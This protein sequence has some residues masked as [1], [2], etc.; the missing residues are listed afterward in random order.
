MSCCQQILDPLWVV[1]SANPWVPEC[2]N[3]S[4]G[5]WWREREWSNY[6]AEDSYFG[7]GYGGQFV[8]IFPSWDMIIVANAKWGVAQSEANQ[9]ANQILNAIDDNILSAVGD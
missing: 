7:W 5:L 3:Q 2:C 9:V 8:I 4:Y 1:E 6:F